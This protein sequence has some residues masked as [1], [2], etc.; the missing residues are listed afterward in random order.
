MRTT[1]KKVFISST[2]IDLPE[3]RKAAIHACQRL[4]FV[5]LCMEEFPPD[6]RDAV[7]VCLE[8]V[9]E[10]N[11]YLGIYAYRYGFVPDGSE[12]SLTEMEYQRAL[13]R[14][15]PVLIFV[16]DPDFPWL[17]SQ[18]EKGLGAERLEKFKIEI[19]RRHVFRKFREVHGFRE[20]LLIFL[21]AQLLV[22]DEKEEK[23]PPAESRL[24]SMSPTETRGQR[25][26]L[27]PRKRLQSST[28]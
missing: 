13:E 8:H 5:P 20:D 10:A 17:P 21:P 1:P 25:G 26:S 23:E 27:L 4:G 19:G 12:I 18:I 24:V 14:G 6:P 3:Y 15:L 22:A 2:A 7:S 11:A 16:V 28:V 9:G